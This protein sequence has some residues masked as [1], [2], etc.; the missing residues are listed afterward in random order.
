MNPLV[1]DVV[2]RVE[3]SNSQPTV[4]ET[5]TLP[6]ELHPYSFTHFIH[7][8][9]PPDSYRES[10]TRILYSF[11]SVLLYLPD[12]YRRATPVFLLLI[13]FSVTLPP[14][15]YRGELHPYSFNRFIQCYLPP[16]SYRRATPVFL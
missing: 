10:Y 5:A 4:L 13:L 2:A 9:L 12:S 6:I 7:Q 16:D 3:D 14:D 15:S 1:V 8:A 11:Y